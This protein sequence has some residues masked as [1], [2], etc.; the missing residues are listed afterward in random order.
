MPTLQVIDRQ[1]DANAA[2]ILQGANQISDALQKRQ[3]M[4]LTADELRIKAKTAENEYEKLKF[5]K[6]AKL[7]DDMSTLLKEGGNDEFKA[8]KMK[9]WSRA[10][11]GG[12]DK[13]M[14]DAFGL[15]NGTA[16]EMLKILKPGEGGATEEQ[17]RGALAKKNLAE[18]ETSNQTAALLQQA[19]GGGS[20]LP[21]TGDARAAVM[22]T[23]GGG[24]A[25]VNGQPVSS[26]RPLVTK[27]VGG[28]PTIE[29]PENVASIARTTT[30]ANAMANQEVRA[31]QVR[32]VIDG[33]REQLGKAFAEMGG[34]GTS[35]LEARIKGWAYS[36]ASDIGNLPETQAVKA[37][38]ESTSLSLA[39][40][41]NQGRPTEPDRVAMEKILPRTSYMDAT[42]KAL[43]RYIDR[44]MLDPSVQQG[45]IATKER[46]K[47]TGE[48]LYTNPVQRIALET[49]K[50]EIIDRD[51]EFV[52]MQLDKGKSMK[53]INEALE[54]LHAQR[55]Y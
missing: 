2:M 10:H 24:A 41:V 34:P 28:S 45:S 54:L 55:G 6:A 5:D 43:D 38:L 12:D 47:V 53:Q 17:A 15:V 18:A 16:Q 9:M 48:I 46:D 19:T 20:S 40:F 29:F 26:N 36:A 35:A 7:S 50:K 51:Q 21:T 23:P 44:L 14:Y 32:P 25:D 1:P 4:Q 3:A 30:M 13:A 8:A 27:I 22:S 33:Y 11:F 49:A 42:N 31:M 52:R 39:A 37:I